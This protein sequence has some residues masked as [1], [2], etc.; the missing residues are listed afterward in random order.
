MLSSLWGVYGGGNSDL[1]VQELP[2][3][4]EVKEEIDCRMAPPIDPQLQERVS[5]STCLGNTLGLALQE[6]KQQHD[7]A[8][9][10]KA[11]DATVPVNW[12]HDRVLGYTASAADDRRLTTIQDFVLRCYR[13]RLQRECISFLVRTHGTDWARKEKGG[14][15][16]ITAM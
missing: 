6:V 7:L 5:A 15:A 11:D 16:D 3:R 14:L 8:K 13:R 2:A 1:G 10:V 12:W 9:A 4:L